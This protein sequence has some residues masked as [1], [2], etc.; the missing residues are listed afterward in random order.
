M[1]I[2]E[3]FVSNSSSSS[4][5]IGVKGKLTVAKLIKAFHVTEKSPLF[6]LAREIAILMVANSSATTGA[7]YKE[8]HCLNRVPPIFKTIAEKEMTAYY[9]VAEDQNGNNLEAALCDME[10]NYEGDDL[11]IEKDKG[12]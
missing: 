11:I 12:Y 7:E 4:F 3:S 9:G 2:R 6:P 1:K 10:L 5:I 8:E